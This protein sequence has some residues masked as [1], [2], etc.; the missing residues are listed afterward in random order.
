MVI[1]INGAFGVGKTSVAR[2]LVEL[3][4]GASLVDPEMLGGVLQRLLPRRPRDFQ[5]MPA[6]RRGT[7]RAVRIASRIRGCIVVPMTLVAPAYF[8]E[9]VGTLRRHE[10]VRHFMLL[11]SADAIAARLRLRGSSG[12]AIEQIDRCTAVQSE[13]MFARHIWTE[14]KDIEA[15]A[16]E[17]AGLLERGEDRSQEFP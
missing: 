4:D 3:L 13:P 17:I 14:G 12:W 5:D 15:I 9:V 1:W 10:D 11:A 6:W 2:R 7:V 16:G 8:Q